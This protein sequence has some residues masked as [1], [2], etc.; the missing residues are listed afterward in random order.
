MSSDCKPNRHGEPPTRGEEVGE[1]ISGSQH[2]PRAMVT[3]RVDGGAWR[4]Y[5]QRSR[6]LK[7]QERRRV[8]TVQVSATPLPAACCGGIAG[9]TGG[10]EASQS[11]RR[12]RRRFVLREVT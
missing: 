4:V 2:R 8:A 10:A 11:P 5:P 12:S 1:F 3:R 7:I 9:A 6:F